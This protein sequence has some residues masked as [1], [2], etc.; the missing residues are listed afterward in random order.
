MK[1]SKTAA[2]SDTK[3]ETEAYKRF[4]KQPAFSFITMDERLEDAF[5]SGFRASH[6][7]W[8]RKDE[9]RKKREK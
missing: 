6:A 8:L 9:L 3:A 7:I 1:G 5:R 2:G 4:A